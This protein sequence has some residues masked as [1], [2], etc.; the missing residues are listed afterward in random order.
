MMQP[1]S[2][3]MVSVLIPAFNEEKYIRQTLEALFL[4]DYPH[5]EIIVADNASTD[6]SSAIVRQFME[7]NVFNKLSLTLLYEAKKGTNH[8][9][10]CARKAASGSIIA[11]IDADCLP[12]KDWISKGVAAICDHHMYAAVTG[13]YDYFDSKQELRF[14][15]LFAQKVFYPVINTLVQR[16]GRGAILIGGNAFIRADILAYIGG[17]N[18]TLTFY[19]DDVDLGKQLARIG[20]VAFQPSL[21]LLS[22]SRRYKAGGFW[23]V[24]KKYQRYFWNLIWGRNELLNTMEHQHPR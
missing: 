9:R 20:F 22:S 15:S 21:V 18:T 23:Q 2:L 14:F 1:F 11:Q 7:R 19:G 13:P 17:Y 4:Q 6:R 16:F 24:N 12:A 3:P 10:E 8:A 5:F